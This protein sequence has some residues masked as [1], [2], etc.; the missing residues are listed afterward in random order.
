MPIKNRVSI[1]SVFVAALLLCEPAALAQRQPSSL[2]AQP[3]T[4]AA[5]KRFELT[6]DSIMRGPELVGYEP[7]RVVWSQDS[8]RVFFRWKRAGEPRLKEPD[9]YVVGRDGTGLRKLS[10]DEARQQAPP[11]SGEL[12]KDR[13]LTVFTE[14]GDVYLYDHAKGERRALTRTVDVETNARF[15]GDQKRVYFTRQNNLYVISLDGGLLEQL[16]DIRTGGGGG[17]PQAGATPPRAGSES[18]EVVRREERSLLEAVRERAEQREEQEARRRKRERRRPFPIPGGQTVS[19]LTLSP[20]GAY[21]IASVGEQAPGAKATIVPSYV[22]ETAYT[23]DINSRTKVGDLQGRTRMAVVSVE[24]GEFKW[25]EHGQKVE[26]APSVRTRTEA[27]STE[28]AQRERG[29]TAQ[30]VQ[31]TPPQQSQQ[32]AAQQSQTQAQQQSQTQQATTQQQQG[33]TEATAQARD[34]DVQLFQLQWSE[35][36]KRAALLAR[37]SDNKDRW[38]LSLDPSTGKT[39]VLA[40]IHDDAW[41]GG[42]GSFTLGWLPDSRRVY[43]MAER[44]GFAHLYTVPADGGEPSQ[45][46]SGRFEVSDV[47]LSRDKTK[48]Y[49]TSSEGSNF[50]ER[51]LYTMPVEGGARTRLTSLPGNNQTD[52]SPDETTLA[53]INS[54]SNRP[55]E[56]FLEPNSPP[57]PTGARARVPS[58]VTTSP[59]PEFSTY[60]WIDPPIVT[61]KARDGAD[62]HARLYKP[63]NFRRGGPA[64]VFVHGAGYLQNVHKWW[65]SYYRE[66]MFHHLLMERGFTVLDIDYRGSAGYGR[67]WRTGIYRHMGGKDLTDHVDGARYLTGEHGV[68]PKRIGI[69]GGSYGG[70]ITFMAMFTEPDVFAAGAAL[71]PVADWAHYNHPYTANI[72]NTPQSDLEA[73]K[74]SSPIYFA[75]GL[76][77]ALLIC[78]GMVD[79]NVHFQD[80][81]RL[82]QRLIELRKENWELAVYPVEDHSFERASSWADEYKRI[83]KLFEENL[84]ATQPS[85]R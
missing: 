49:F 78:H 44:D 46:T 2:S 13:T 56:L 11:A 26:V 30:G 83:L 58:R 62:V 33:Q 31:P 5:A 75:E 71:R 61:F 7:T 79:T 39:R 77:G 14:D 45:L 15:T 41:V 6:V 63:A 85:V 82:V 32:Q 18:Q 8:S 1:L 60:N 65:S 29:E 43:F 27:N 74:R 55:P 59:I 57:P 52:I 47:R 50:F 42:P 36:G 22:T 48:F 64:V 10:E 16:T 73:Y 70:F 67:D 54:Y 25:I 66:Y 17:G 20:D 68:D 3:Q 21:V 76:K 72:L 80:T 37:A 34:R 84:R 81:V 69:Y 19:N 38:V 24:T 35:D 51:H 23:E 28:Q 12:S 53:V 40:R 9:T 4:A